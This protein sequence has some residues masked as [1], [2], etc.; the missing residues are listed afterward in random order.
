MGTVGKLRGSEYGVVIEHHDR[1]E[2]RVS[3]RSLAG[4]IKTVNYE[5]NEGIQY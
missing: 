4:D 1:E 2:W 3:L 5:W